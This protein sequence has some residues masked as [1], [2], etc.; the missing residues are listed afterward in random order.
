L[1]VAEL[2]LPAMSVQ[3]TDLHS[4]DDD[5]NDFN[6]L[7]VKTQNKKTKTVT[8]GDTTGQIAG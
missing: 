5:L 8:P 3:E 4:S 6:S 2:D 7:K 1:E